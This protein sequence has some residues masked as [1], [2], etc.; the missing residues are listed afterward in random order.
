MIE[1]NGG[2]PQKP[3]AKLLE[4]FP[5][6]LGFGARPRVHRGLPGLAGKGERAARQ[7]NSFRAPLSAPDSVAD[8]SGELL[9]RYWPASYR[10]LGLR[11]PEPTGAE[12]R[13]D[14][15]ARGF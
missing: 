4:P 12:F 7:R 6:P 1:D 2:L 9:C 8:Y 10:A 14:Y 15:P 5:P 11:S 13:R 3:L